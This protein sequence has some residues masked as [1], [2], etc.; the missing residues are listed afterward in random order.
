MYKNIAIS[1]S[2]EFGP[3]VV[4][5]IAL[6]FLG[7]TDTG[8]ITSTT[9]FSILTGVALLVS[10]LYEQRIAWF[11]LIAGV[12]V[13]TFGVLTVIFKEPA[14]F[15]LKDTL[16]N[17]FFGVFLLMGT[18]TGKGFLKKLFVAL[19][20]MNDKGWFILSFRWGVFFLLLAIF[21]EIIWRVFGRDAW[22][23]YKFWSTIAT[24][25]FGLYQITLSK[26]YRNEEASPWGL[27]TKPYHAPTILD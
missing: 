10:Y 23:L 18:Y 1:W 24:V 4:F 8:F 27:R 11:P 19:F 15:I 2:I 22:V 26:K 13:I 14:L 25:V 5:F 16:Y 9:I 12:S 6:H 17:G 3:I 21:N 7:E 20:N